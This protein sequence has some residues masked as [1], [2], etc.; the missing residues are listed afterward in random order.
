MTS[1][2]WQVESIEAFSFYCCPECVFRSRDDYLFQSHALQNHAKSNLLFNLQNYE[3]KFEIEDIKQEEQD[4]LK[5]DVTN[6]DNDTF[7]EDISQDIND[8]IDD[9]KDTLDLIKGV[10]EIG[11]SQNEN[12][13]YDQDRIERFCC[14]DCGKQCKSKKDLKNHM[15]YHKYYLNGAQEFCGRCQ[16]NVP[17]KL[18]PTH[19]E[20]VHSKDDDFDILNDQKHLE[21]KEKYLNF[22]S[23][24]YLRLSFEFQST[25]STAPL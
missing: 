11:K 9:Y 4:E 14:N 2:P 5:P 21:G 17:E 10:E 22:C 3:T 19:L 6:S 23:V 7:H 18:F 24:Y 20:T 15:Y 1:N 25:Q 8:E 13:N 12:V 16:K